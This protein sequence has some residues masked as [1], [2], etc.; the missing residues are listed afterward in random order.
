MSRHTDN[1]DTLLDRIRWH[2]AHHEMKA[3]W[4]DNTVE[5]MFDTRSDKERC[6]IDGLL[7]A[8]EELNRCRYGEPK[9]PPPTYE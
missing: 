5:N 4:L 7:E 1:L 9:P 2:I 6:R 8:W 3:E